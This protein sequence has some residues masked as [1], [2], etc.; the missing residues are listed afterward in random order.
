MAIPNKDDIIHQRN[1]E[2]ELIPQTVELETV[3]NSAKRFLG[4]EDDEPLE[5][6]MRPAKQG[7]LAELMQTA[8]QE[9]EEGEEDQVTNSEMEFVSERIIK[10]DIDAED[11]EYAKSQEIMG[12]ALIALISI[13][14]GNPQDEV[15]E[16]IEES[17][18]DMDEE[19]LFQGTDDSES[20]DEDEGSDQGGSQ[21]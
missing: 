15:A 9:E 7:E 10:P 17:M 2:N 5:F 19:E 11:M 14:T 20:E 21:G 6:R 12:S 13:S 4:V 16:A 1:E 18:E 8:S 3:S